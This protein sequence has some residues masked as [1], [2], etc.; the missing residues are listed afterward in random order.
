DR[1]NEERRVAAPAA[2][3]GAEIA[4]GACSRAASGRARGGD[5]RALA[6]QGGE[7]AGIERLE[8]KPPAFWFGQALG[9]K[10][11][12]ALV[13]VL[14]QFLDQVGVGVGIAGRMRQALADPWTGAGSRVRPPVRHRCLR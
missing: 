1:E 2:E 4:A 5:A 13:K 9:A 6:L 10:L 3:G 11:A 8:N 12:V 7:V 14:G